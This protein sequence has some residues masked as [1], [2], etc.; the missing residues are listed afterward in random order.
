MTL[1]VLELDSFTEARTDDDKLAAAIKAARAQPQRPTIVLG[2]R[3]H[4]FQR[5]HSLFDGMR[6]SGPLGGLEREFNSQCKVKVLGP[7]LFD[8]QGPVRDVSIRGVC[9]EGSG[10]NYWLAPVKDLGSGHLLSDATIVDGGWKDF[11]SVMRARLLRCHIDRTYTQGC[12]E[13]DFHLAGSDNTLWPTPYAS[14]MSSRRKTQHRGDTDIPAGGQP[15]LV[16]AHM[17]VTRVGGLYLTPEG[18]RNAV[19]VEDSYGGLVFDGVRFDGSGR[20]KSQS[21]QYSAI[22]IGGGRGVTVDRCEYFNVSTS[23]KA[24]AVIVID[25]GEGHVVRH[26]SFLG[27]QAH[28]SSTPPHVQA[29]RS[30]MPTRVEGL[31][32]VAG[33]NTAFTVGVPR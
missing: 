16:F 31:H 7:H 2:N 9:F 25:G 29:V 13:I 8:M 19:V 12:S 6:L 21:C 28:E 1:G 4:L 23:D 3:P 5:P 32:S 20:S 10:D 30:R 22:W 17:S 26:C 14:F 24:S 18:V 33:G 15:Y 11:R 27:Q